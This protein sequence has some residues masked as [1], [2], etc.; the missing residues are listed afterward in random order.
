MP[1]GRII[2]RIIVFEVSAAFMHMFAHIAMPSPIIMPA[3]V[4]Q[5]CSHAEQASIHSCIIAMSMPDAGMSFWW[6]SIICIAGFIM[7]AIHPEVP[8]TSRCR[9]RVRHPTDSMLRRG[10]TDGWGSVRAHLA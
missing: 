2:I 7:G 1:F 5:A 6:F 8:G 9:C 3:Q 4:V 10:R